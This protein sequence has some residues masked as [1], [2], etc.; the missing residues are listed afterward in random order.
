MISYRHHTVKPEGG[1]VRPRAVAYRFVMTWI[2][3]LE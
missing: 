2:T 3:P 1:V